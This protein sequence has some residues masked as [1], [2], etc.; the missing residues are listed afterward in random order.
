MSFTR[1]APGM[2]A[3]SQVAMPAPTSST[4]NALSS[5]AANNSGL[6]GGWLNLHMEIMMEKQRVRMVTRVRLDAHEVEVYI[7]PWDG[8]PE[9]LMVNYGYALDEVVFTVMEIYHD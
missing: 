5:S 1:L 9:W 2:N 3:L 6:V 7:G 4:R 8:Y